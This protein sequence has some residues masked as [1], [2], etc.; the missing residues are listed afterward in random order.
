MRTFSWRWRDPE[1]LEAHRHEFTRPV[2][3]ILEEL[4][5]VVRAESGQE[6]SQGGFVRRWV[7]IDAE[8]SGPVG[9]SG[10]RSVDPDGSMSFWAYRRGRQI[11]SHLCL[12]EG[13][14]TNRACIW[15]WWEDAEFVIHTLYPGRVAPRE[16]HDPEI[17][18]GELPVAIE[19]WRQ[20]AILTHE[21]AYAHEPY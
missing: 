18:L 12:G 17:P 10:L 20:H 2:E 4:R 11:P 3:E 15:G 13:E 19:F 9:V 6:R 14:L 16:I 1:H 7:H 8:L 21:G 5:P